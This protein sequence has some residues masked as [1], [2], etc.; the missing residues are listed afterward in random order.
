MIKKII[1]LI[2][3]IIL[4][5]TTL[6][7]YLQKDT[8]AQYINE[9]F[10]TQ[11]ISGGVEELIGLKNTDGRTNFLILG[12]DTRQ[13][14]SSINT[15]LT[16]S[17]MVLSMNKDNGDVTLI[18][19]PRDLWIP[20]IGYKINAVYTITKG[21]IEEV[22]KVVSSIV[23]LEIHYYSIVNFQV[24]TDLIDDLGGIEINVPNAFTDYKYP[25]EGREDAPENLR[26][27]TLTFKSG[28]QTMDGETALKYARSRHAANIE[29]AGDF[30]RARRQQIVIEAI[31]NKVLSADSLFNA[32][33][34]LNLYST[35]A[36]NVETDFKLPQATFFIKN[37]EQVRNGMIK[38][39]VLSNETYNE[40]IPGS[41]LLRANTTE[42]K[43]NIHRNQFVLIPV[44]NTYEAIQVL[45]RSHLFQSDKSN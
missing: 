29:E 31:K 1:S 18:S 30:A 5:V 23:G 21:D 39:I 44:A 20:S 9:L 37:I 8:L 35:Y 34:F 7:I 6:F 19:I 26:Y 4:V 43:E 25:I 33:K 16:D 12:T 3:L 2:F 13:N 10:S 45:I 28:L 41:G 38:N 27:E 24:F 15:K 11:I 17:I 32:N 14:G 42:E 36:D 40:N 22:K